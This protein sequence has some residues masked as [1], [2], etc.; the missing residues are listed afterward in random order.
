[1]LQLKRR[2]TLYLIRLAYRVG[3]LSR[4]VTGVLD[5]MFV[6]IALRVWVRLRMG[7]LWGHHT[8]I[9]GWRCCIWHRPLSVWRSLLLN[10]VVDTCFVDI[11]IL[12]RMHR[13]RM[14]CTLSI[15]G[16]LETVQGALGVLNWEALMLLVLASV[17]GIFLLLEN[18]LRDLVDLWH[19]AYRMKTLLVR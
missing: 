4:A 14:V 5:G 8:L 9:K 10:N 1:M 17:W 11:I 19:V 13:D 3:C 6:W 12:N 7:V 18:L 2:T 16:L 15:L